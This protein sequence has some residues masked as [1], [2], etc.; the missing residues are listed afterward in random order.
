MKTSKLY[1]FDG[2]VL[3]VSGASSGIGRATALLFAK[4]NAKVMVADI[5]K[6]AGLQTARMIADAGGF[7]EF[8]PCNVANESEVKEAIKATVRSFGK[9]DFA[10]NNAG[11]EGLQ[12]TTA[13]C[14]L[15]NWNQVIQTNLSGVWFAMKYELE[16]MLRQ[17]GGVIVNCSSIAGLVGFSAIPAYVASKHGVLGLTKTAA[18]EYARLNIRVNAVCP[19]VIRTPMVDRFVH[20]DEKVLSS[21]TQNEPMGRI[22]QPEEIAE[23]V[24]WLCSDASSFVTGHP[25]VVDGGWV[26]Q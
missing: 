7:A 17:Q 8:V 13:D 23:S 15:E 1:N 3:F 22:G 4:C 16:Q 21:L 25:L 10:F 12:A 14:T 24:A 19:G 26:V 18:L 9:I 11:I 20:G 5:D 6:D 2:K